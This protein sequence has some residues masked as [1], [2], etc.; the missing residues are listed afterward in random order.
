MLTIAAIADLHGDFTMPEF[1]ADV[2]ILA[3]DILS[4]NYSAIRFSHFLDELRKRFDRVYMIAGNHDIYFEKYDTPELDLYRIH[5]YANYN[6][7]TFYGFP[8][9]YLTINGVQKYLRDWAFYMS[10]QSQTAYLSDI[11]NVDIFVSHGPPLGYCDE[12][13]HGEHLGS[14]AVTDFIMKNK[15]K[16]VLCGHIHEA[17]G[18]AEI[19]HEDGSET[20][21][22]NCARGWAKVTVE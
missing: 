4:D 6:R 22:V 3:G 8:Y 19:I 18:M 16:L 15:P 12:S 11:S 10:N 20:K 7:Y 14:K 2:A 21:V 9:T 13:I 17:R 1:D 5:G